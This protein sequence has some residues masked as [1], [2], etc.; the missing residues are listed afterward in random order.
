[1]RT[2]SKVMANSPSRAA[3]ARAAAEKTGSKPKWPERP[4]PDRAAPLGA[5]LQEAMPTAASNAAK[6]RI[7]VRNTPQPAR[8][9]E[10]CQASGSHR[11]TELERQMFARK[12]S[13]R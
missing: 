5:S 6:V 13:L 11:R 10:P 2:R 7:D 3:V 12:D 4:A 9:T 8:Q 1:M